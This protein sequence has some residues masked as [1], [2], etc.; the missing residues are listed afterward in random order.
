MAKKGRRLNIPVKIY[1]LCLVLISFVLTDVTVSKYI[2]SDLGGDSA[3]VAKLGKLYITENGNEYDSDVKWTVVPGVDITKNAVINFE[4]SEL[5][6]YVFFSVETEGFVKN[7]SNYSYNGL[8][9]FSIENTWESFNSD[10]TTV[11]YTVVEPGEKISIPV[12]SNEGKIKVSEE[13]TAS[14]IAEAV[15]NI[16]INIKATAVQYGGFESV[17]AAYNA[18]R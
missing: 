15:N 4:S 6:C 2:E 8:M 17:E 12:I 10:E 5:A 7:G 14:Q 11:Y 16:S 3:R 18:V 9:E 1:L 13:I